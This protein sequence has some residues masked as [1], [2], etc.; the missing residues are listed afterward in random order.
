MAILIAV[1][2]GASAL[3]QLAR[4]PTDSRQG[5]TPGA[6]WSGNEA[7]E[8]GG[9]ADAAAPRAIA[10]EQ[11]A[12]PFAQNA[13]QLERIAPRAPLTPTVERDTGPRPTLLHKPLVIAAGEIVFPEGGLR[14]KGI[15]VTDPDDICSD[16]DGRLWPC[17]I[18]ARTAFRNFVGGRS[19]SCNLPEERWKEIVVVSCLVGKQDPAAWLASSGWVRTFV[20]SKYA[21]LE[22][23]AQKEAKGIFGSDPRG[24]ASVPDS[25]RVVSP[26]GVSPLPDPLPV[27]LR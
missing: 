3:Y 17:G 21:D 5:K 1:I 23:D 11:F 4:D 6:V 2:A 27:P 22:Q 19:L 20:G 26:D 12:T 14:L 7:G 25:G 13:V 16:Q 18:I 24:L 8:N 10:P 9:V 15:V